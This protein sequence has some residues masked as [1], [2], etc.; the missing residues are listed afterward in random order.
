MVEVVIV[1]VMVVIVILMVVVEEDD[2]VAAWNREWNW[3]SC[4]SPD[5]SERHCE[6]V[7]MLVQ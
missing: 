6:V 2:A 3:S 5:W 1:T 7:S 4:E